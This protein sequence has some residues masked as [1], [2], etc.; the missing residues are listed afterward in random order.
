MRRA[1]F[2]F[3]AVLGTLVLAGCAG[4]GG[5]TATP[6]PTATLTST[7]TSTPTFTNTPPPTATPVPPTPTAVPAT[8][9]PVP[10]TATRTFTAT[11][12]STPTAT[13]TP[14]EVATATVTP[15]AIAPV[16]VAQTLF[17]ELN[18][19]G[20][21]KYLGRAVPEPTVE[22]NWLRYDFATSDDGPICLY[23]TPFRVYVRPGTSENVLFYLEGGGACWN[24]ENCWGDTRAKID[25][26]PIL[27]LALL[28]GGIFA[29]SPQFNP[30]AGWSVVYVPY[31]DG[32]VFTGDNVADYEQGTVWHRGVS[33]LSTGVDV[34]K[35]LYP[36][37]P[38]I[39]VSGSSAGGFGTF[40]GYG[41]TRLAYPTTE[42]L[43]IN[44]SG[45]GLQNNADPQ[46]LAD[47][48]ENWKF[49]QFRPAGCTDC[50]TQ[51]AFLTPWA[52]QY[53]TRLRGGF[54]SS[55]QDEVIRG[56]LEMTGPEYEE[57]LLTATDE[58]V[59][60][61]PERV[62]RFFSAGDFHT[63]LLGG[64]I[65]SS[66]VAADYRSISI[67]GTT[68]PQ[69]LDALVSGDPAWSDLVQGR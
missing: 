3:L 17:D 5:S 2:F 8:P 10:P 41:V 62:K 67:N 16:E 13:A 60:K 64:G 27:P 11:T 59:A 45:P 24:N 53:D 49:E 55:L 7:P 40:S 26:A 1:V 15:T 30:L 12:T 43:V 35:S 61:N 42:I 33:N 4:D 52:M 63:I 44:D 6:T 36:N 28:R 31:C 9:T 23:G 19:V 32:S 21:G 66:G 57:L 56:F 22:G 25:A 29:A 39:V 65:G 18:A 68:L 58:V 54:F 47:R 20:L 14:T 69:W 46:A 34:M 50:P 38:R 37:P 48:R 51:P